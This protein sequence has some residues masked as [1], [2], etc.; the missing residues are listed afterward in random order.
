MLLLNLQGDPYPYARAYF[1][2]EILDNI[3]PECF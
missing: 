2:E 3:V 1:W